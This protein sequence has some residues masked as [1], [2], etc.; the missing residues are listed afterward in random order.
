MTYLTASSDLTRGRCPNRFLFLINP[1][2]AVDENGLKFASVGCTC[3]CS[4]GGLKAGA[5]LGTL[6]PVWTVFE[7]ISLLGVVGLNGRPVEDGPKLKP[8]P[9]GDT[10]NGPGEDPNGCGV[11]RV[12]MGPGVLLG[13]KLKGSWVLLGPKLND[14]CVLGPKLN[15]SWVLLGPKLN[16][17]CVLGP[18]LN[19]LGVLLGPELKGCRGLILCVSNWGSVLML[20]WVLNGLG[21]GLTE[22]NIS[23]AGEVG[24]LLLLLPKD[25]N[26]LGV[27]ASELNPAG[28]GLDGKEGRGGLGKRSSTDWGILG[29]GGGPRLKFGLGL[30]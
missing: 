7:N 5:P 12:L 17:S 20:N 24:P 18:K 4:C 8:F 15:G 1:L 13:P 29:C 28:L 21:V 11:G 6:S 27:V 16:D 25:N 30:F 10:P 26:G 9:P 22:L 3:C 23:L 19:G 14:S 2:R